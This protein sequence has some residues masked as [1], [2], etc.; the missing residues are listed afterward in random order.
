MPDFKLVFRSKIG[1]AKSLSIGNVKIE[2][3]VFSEFLKNMQQVKQYV[4]PVK[5]LFMG[6]DESF[7]DF[8]KLYVEQVLQI[9]PVLASSDEF[10]EDMATEFEQRLGSKR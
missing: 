7:N 6:D 8:L 4:P 1:A 5:V 3:R 2:T 9:S 10:D